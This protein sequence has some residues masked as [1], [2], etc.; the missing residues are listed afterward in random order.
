MNTSS[1]QQNCLFVHE[2]FNLAQM[3]QGENVP[4]N[5]DQLQQLV[6]KHGEQVFYFLH[7]LLA[8][9]H[10]WHRRWAWISLHDR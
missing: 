9:L 8:G 10:E 7:A 1:A 3:M 5:V 4:A 2:T 6:N